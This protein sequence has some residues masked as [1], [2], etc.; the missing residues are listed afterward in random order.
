M[1]KNPFFTEM[2]ILAAARIQRYR[3]TKR[4]SPEIL[5][6]LL[7]WAGQSVSLLGTSMTNFALLLWTYEQQGTATSVAYLSLFTYLPSILLCFIA[8]AVADRWDKKKI[9]LISDLLAALGTVCV[10]CLY[11]TNRLAP[12]HLYAVNF[13]LS[14]MNAFTHPAVNVA[15]SLITPKQ[16]YVRANSLYAMSSSLVT[17][18]TPSLATLLYVWGGLP[19]VFIVDLTTFAVAFGSLLFGVR[20]PK[21][22]RKAEGAAE[23]FRQ[24][25]QLGLRY[26]FGHKALL[27]LIGF[28]TFINLTANIGAMGLKSVYIL[29]RTGGNEAILG[30]VSTAVG[31]GALVGSLLVTLAKPAKSR[32]RVILWSCGLSTLCVDF[33]LGLT[34]N[35][36]LWIAGCCLG[37]VFMPFLN[38]NL[39]AT[40]R[41]QVPLELHGRVFS[42]Q[43]TLQCFTIP[44]GLFVG[45]HLADHVFEPLMQ[46]GST[47]AQLLSPLVGTA[48]GSGIAV[49]LLITGTLQVTATAFAL[50][51]PRY[52]ELDTSP[53]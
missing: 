41:Y 6:F 27:R 37:E 8:G 23:P 46:S 39:T 15:L 44:L 34:N 2:R 9:M 50:F 47:L 1:K 49:M 30:T 14:C 51:D 43:S 16:H 29:T 20:I 21:V 52:R 28:F 7:L 25:L 22:Q 5:T 31:I 17:I 13:A 18:L 12:W 10:F 35:P 32:T 40:M 42:A 38:G 53:N 33:V 3:A 19:A 11:A 36:L 26:L 45:G 24:S 4:I 48:P